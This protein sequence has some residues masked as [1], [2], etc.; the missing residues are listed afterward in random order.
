VELHAAF[1]PSV[2]ND[3]CNV[4]NV[5]RR[6]GDVEDGNNRQCAANANEI[7]TGAKSDDEPNSVDG[8][9]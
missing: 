5:K 1:V 6:S 7:E 8:S 4:T 3:N 2:R 9:I